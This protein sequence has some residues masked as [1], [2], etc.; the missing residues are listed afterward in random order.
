MAS[1]P[2]TRPYWGRC[3]PI[4]KGP[5]TGSLRAVGADGRAAPDLGHVLD[6]LVGAVVAGDRRAQVRV[7]A[8]RALVAGHDPDVE[9]VLRPLHQRPA[10]RVALRL[11]RAMVGA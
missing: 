5:T 2:A 3:E 11:R 4:L 7:H 8:L 9:Q 6:R 10:H 1:G